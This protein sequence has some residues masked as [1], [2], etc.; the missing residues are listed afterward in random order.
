VPSGCGFEAAAEGRGLALRNYP[1]SPLSGEYAQVV[2]RLNLELMH[3]EAE[4]LRL[5]GATA[6]LDPS[7]G[8]CCVSL[9]PAAPTG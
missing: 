9:R 2:C 1:F 6:G 5:P 4:G 3:G 7:S 8:P